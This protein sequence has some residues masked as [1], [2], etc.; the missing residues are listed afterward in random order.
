MDTYLIKYLNSGKAWL[1][2]GSGPSIEMGYPTWEELAKKAV[3]IIEV[4][5]HG[6]PQGA[7]TRA[8]QHKDFPQVFEE[9][10]KILGGPR[11]LEILRQNFKGKKPGRIYEIISK[12]PIPIYMTTNYD[13]EIGNHLTNIGVAHKTYSNSLDHMSLINDELQGAI[14]K[15]HGDLTSETGLILTSSQYKELEN[16]SNWNYWKSRLSAIFQM[17]YVII[18]G[19]SLTDNN[20]RLVLE[21]AKEASGVE[22]PICWLAPDVERDVVKEYLEKYRIRV[23]TYDNKDGCHRN[24]VRY[25]ET[26]ND[27]I[28]PRTSIKIQKNIAQIMDSPLGLNAAAPGFFVFSKLAGQS[29]F[30]NTRI[31][32]ILAALQSV[33]PQLQKKPYF[34]LDEALG[35]LGWSVQEVP[36]HIDFK[37]QILE[38]AIK[39]GLFEKYDGKFRVDEDAETNFQI[40]HGQFSHLRDGFKLSLSLRLQRDFP[41][42]NSSVVNQIASDIE[43][44]LTGYF[45]EG[46]LSLATLLLSPKFPSR[47]TNIPSSIIRFINQASAKYE[48]LLE[49]QAFSYESVAVFVHSEEI[50]RKYLGRI[51]QGFFAFHALGMFG[52]SAKKIIENARNTVWLVDSN[53]Q[54][55][56]LSFPAPTSTAFRD[57]ILHLNNLGLRFFTTEKLFDETVSHFRFANKVI[58]DHGSPSSHYVMAAATGQ[59]PYPKS[60]QFLAGFI[61]WQAGGNPCDWQEY[62]FTI[63]GSHSPTDKDVKNA[64]LKL[65]IEVVPFKCWP[66]FNEVDYSFRDEILEKLI[67]LQGSLRNHDEIVQYDELRDQDYISDPYKKAEPEAE[68][69]AI[70]IKE[71]EGLYN[72]LSQR[73]EKSTAWFISSTSLLNSIENTRITMQPEAFFKFSQTLSTSTSD[74]SADRAFDIILWGIAESGVSILDEDLLANVFGGVID[75]ASISD[76]STRK[77]YEEMLEVKY[78]ESKESILARIRP[79]DRPMA[80]LQLANEIFQKEA[81]IRI[82][83]QMAA[84]EANKRASSAEKELDR[85]NKFRLRSLRKQQENARIAKQRKAGRQKN[86]KKRG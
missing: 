83:A 66:G 9:A 78:G 38:Q 68:A 41:S 75:Y 52:D 25:I 61:N 79:V 12:W 63:F 62:L 30:D 22:R 72:I 58:K 19:H 40:N 23:I 60:N 46:G 74:I 59:L 4:E 34:T 2:I 53:I 47:P 29:N 85:L 77:S 13:D 84:D 70:I 55:H 35:L 5:G 1:L 49:R 14:L 69:Y 16:G 42:L 36:L 17:Q 3:E 67:I 81:K 57:C 50:E 48:N 11:L 33:I 31:E 73:G 80:A 54:I 26:I 65:G 20:I 86:K 10:K 82:Q 27:F 76:E 24:L 18:I 37:N 28:P 56:A 39:Q 8:L 32:V 7:L 44:S 21:I 45:R 43:A 64:L 6:N 15:L 71:R 51:S